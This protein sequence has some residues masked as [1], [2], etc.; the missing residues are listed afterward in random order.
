MTDRRTPDPRRTA[1][2]FTPTGRHVWLA[3]L[4]V[5]PAARRLLRAA[6]AR[7]RKPSGR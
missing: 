6:V 2:P 7:V 1:V 3:A 5:L 4:G